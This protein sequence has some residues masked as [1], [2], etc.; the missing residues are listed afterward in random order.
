MSDPENLGPRARTQT[1]KGIQYE[2]E[3]LQRK[4]KS[5]ISHIYKDFDSAYHLLEEK[6]PADPG[7]LGIASCLQTKFDELQTITSRL[8]ALVTDESVIAQMDKEVDQLRATQR[9][10]FNQIVETTDHDD[11]KGKEE[12][13]AHKP[14]T[15]FPPQPQG[16]L[17]DKF[18]T[19]GPMVRPK[20][21]PESKLTPTQSLSGSSKRSKTSSKTRGNVAALEV[22]LKEERKLR[23]VEEELEEERRKFEEEQ[24]RK[25]R[26]LHEMRIQSELEAERARAEAE[27]SDHSQ[28]LGSEDESEDEWKMPT[29]YQGLSQP[30]A[31]PLPKN[32]NGQRENARPT[33]NHHYSAP[34][35]E[36]RQDVEK[37]LNPNGMAEQT[38]LT[39]LANAFNATRLP[40]PEPPIF[41]GEPLYY[42][43]WAAAFDALVDGKGIPTSDKIFYLSK[44]LAGPAKEAVQCYFRLRSEAGYK[45]ARAVL[46]NRYG[47]DFKIAESFRKKLETWPKIAPVDHQGLQRFS[48]FLNQCQ[49]AMLQIEDLKYLNDPRELAKLADKLPIHLLRQWQKRC[50][51]FKAE[52]KIFP[53]FEEFADFVL[54]QS[55]L[56]N[57]PVI[58]CT[59]Q[60]QTGPNKTAKVLATHATPKEENQSSRNRPQ[61]VQ[62]TNKLCT[63]CQSKEHFL[64]RCPQFAKE[65]K[66]RRIEYLK[67]EN[68]CFKC[69]RQ[70]HY[71]RN[72]PRPHKCEVCGENHPTCLHDINEA[73]KASASS[74]VVSMKVKTQ[75]ATTTTSIVP[76]MV[77]SKENPT[78]EVLTYAILDSGSDAT[79]IDEDTI[80]ALELPRALPTKLTIETINSEER[81]EIESTIQ[82][83]LQVRGYNSQTLINLPP[84]YS[85]ADIPTN[86][87]SIPSQEDIMKWSH[88]KPLKGQIPPPFKC[89]IGLLIGHNCWQALIPRQTSVG[90]NDEPFGVRTDLGWSI[91]GPIARKQKTYKGNKLV[92]CN[93][94]VTSHKPTL[95]PRDACSILERDF[96]EETGSE[97]KTSQEDIQFIRTIENSIEKNEE[98]Y[99]E[100]P[101]PFRNEPNLPNNKVMA[102]KRLELLKRKLQHNQELKQEYISFMQ[103]IIDNGDAEETVQEEE[104][105]WYLPHHG[106]YH[107]K[108]RKLR[109]VFD[110]A[111]TFKGTSLNDHLLSGP[112][113]MNDL[114]GVFMRFRRDQVAI[115]CDVESMFHRFRVSPHHRRYLKFLWWKDGNLMTEPTVYRMKVHIFGATSSPACANFGMKFMAREMESSHPKAAGFIRD[116]FYVDDGLISV[117][118]DEEAIQLIKESTTILKDHKLRLHKFA[119]NSKTVLDSI[120]PTERSENEVTQHLQL[121]E[122]SNEKTLGME[123]ST[124]EDILRF[125]NISANSP[126]TRRGILSVVASL[127]DPLGLIAPFTLKGKLILQE[128][129]AKGSKWDDIVSEDLNSRWEAWKN[130]LQG[131][132]QVTIPRCYT[133]K[134]F[135]TPKSIQLHHF[136]DASSQGYGMCS[137]LRFVNERN[138]VHCALVAAKS[139]VAP[140]KAMTIPRMEL[141]AAVIAAKIGNSI[142]KLIK[143]KIDQEFFWSDSQV[144][145]G[146]L[147]NEAK[148]FHVFVANRVQKI[149]DLTDISKWRHVSTE[150]NPADHASRGLSLDQL[151][152]SNW[153]TGPE[154][155]WN[156]DFQAPSQIPSKLETQDP[157]VRVALQS[158]AFPTPL[159][160]NERLKHI[161]SWPKARRVV[162]KIMGMLDASKKCKETLSPEDLHQ[163][164]RTIIINVQQHFLKREYELISSGKSLKK[165]DPLFGVEPFLKD[166]VLRA[167][168]RLQ[169]DQFSFEERHPAILPKCHVSDLILSHCHELVNHQGKGMTQ[170]EVRS[171]GFWMIG[172]S[173]QIAKLIKNCSV[174]QKLRGK[175]M[176]QQMAKL[177]DERTEPSPPFTFVGM[178]C[179]GPALVKNGRKETKRYGLLFTCL[180]SRA[181]HLEMLDDLTADAFINGLRCL[182]AIRGP[183]QKLFS[184]QGT[185]FIGA[186][187]ELK[188]ELQERLPRTFEDCEFIFNTP[189]ASHAGGVW[190][191]Q[192]GTVKSV[193]KAT[194]ALHPGRLDDS[195]L[196]TF[197]Y[198]VMS[199]VNSRPITTI[200]QDPTSPKPLSPNNVLTMKSRAP[201]PPKGPFLK[202]DIFLRKRW[203]R[204]QYLLEQFWCRWRREYVSEIAK[205]SKWHTPRRN[206]HQDD[207]VLIVDEGSPRNEWNMGRVLNP[208]QSNDGLVRKAT[209]LVGSR[210]LDKNGKRNNQP[211]ILERPVQKLVLIQAAENTQGSSPQ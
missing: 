127:Y 209:V 192:V 178:D 93:R 180:S 104:Q 47:D 78:H 194:M 117:A 43:D 42:A 54:Q 187:N 115:A 205:R 18:F 85:I 177:P 15:K 31:D 201:T 107:P 37:T 70:N 23:R 88:L 102:Q 181:V 193:L 182:I 139:R 71:A 155:L 210:N 8:R 189:H 11:S 48:D 95:K 50:G 83:N 161:S 27:E 124:E 90:K 17:E 51:N 103:K 69:I 76:V 133:P 168:G 204:V 206:L 140:L 46:E 211:S 72:C 61:R 157:E 132:N 208:I 109:V 146:Y 156:P 172:G 176:E 26:N 166:G 148:K 112:N 77:S 59:R 197:L 202:E 84:A 97:E 65:T 20:K 86:Q 137:Y 30:K 188:S 57:D 101:L 190:E 191:R 131:L 134:G 158:N 179:F 125:P 195:S 116:N 145:L 100:M 142:K 36:T 163:A 92:H 39:N 196:R 170:N 82:S 122:T 171:R 113:L 25:R 28:D 99:L 147:Q 105:E 129:C 29:R 6:G 49:T 7:L 9:D 106:V 126:S 110:C 200:S 44:Y 153:Y 152:S 120:P 108:K 22:K 24:A 149:K 58:H 128:A 56:A 62:Q 38:L 74:R 2:I 79:F 207:I 98:G 114:I 96:H 118:T 32:T 60:K 160:L 173:R 75:G 67:K 13:F 198:E 73:W 4:L 123:W 154:W 14:D 41:N 52:R 164:S 151:S 184:D 89:G 203:R 19:S 121:K 10:I 175:V 66:E 186:S 33:R 165:N 40:V 174:C 159:N 34:N 150:S 136:A 55:E 81:K 80:N 144:V 3:T 119:S 185:N 5:A 199:I 167:G 21:T 87:D 143:M 63:F 94:I 64:A 111:A 45:K 91:V 135:G 141:T 12:T 130:E 68:R 183:V 1:E 35:L 162:A 16:Q 138:E 53:R 169:S